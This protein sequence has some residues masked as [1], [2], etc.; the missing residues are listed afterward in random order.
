MNNI[1]YY[2]EKCQYCKEAYNIIKMIG[3]EKF[4]FKDIDKEDIPDIVDRVPTIL[5]SENNNIVVYYENKL[6]E[7]LN[8]MMNIEPFMINEMGGLSDK[9]SYMDNSGINLDHAYQFI[10]KES[11]IITPTETDTNKIINYDKFVT[12]RDNDILIQNTDAK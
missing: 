12:E 5:R 4:L 3:L 2:S 9:Y 11:K 8:E 1:F 7:Y 6:F 10:D